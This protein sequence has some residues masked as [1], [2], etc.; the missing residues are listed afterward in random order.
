MNQHPDRQSFVTIGESVSDVAIPP[1]F[2]IYEN[3]QIVA[4][5][6]KNR[7]LTIA[8]KKFN[9]TEW[10]YWETDSSVGWDSHN[11]IDLG[12]DKSG[13]IHV[14]GNMHASPLQ[15]W[16]IDIHSKT[17]QPRKVEY[18]IN[19][20]NEKKITYPRF[21]RSK[22]G[23]LIFTYRNGISGDGDFIAVEWD[24][25]IG[26]YI[27]ISQKPIIYGE[28]KRN[29]YID[30]N[31]PILGP[32]GRWHLVWAWRN[33][34]SAETTHSVNYAHSDN[35]KLWKTAAGELLD[36]PIVENRESIADPVTTERGLINNNIRLGFLNDSSP[37]IFYH[38]LDDFG[39]QQLWRAAYLNKSWDIRCVSKWDIIWN[40]NGVG[41][42]DFKIEVGTPQSNGIGISIDVR[43]NE[44]IQ[45][46]Y[47]DE[48][49]RPVSSSTA[50]RWSNLMRTTRPDGLINRCLKAKYWIGNA[51]AEEWI[52]SYS[53]VPE[54]RDQRPTSAAHTSR[55]LV[56][57]KI[58]DENK[59]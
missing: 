23:E 42:L 21:M 28:G 43:T 47:F 6:N 29:A 11:Y 15:Y 48:Q 30:T 56:L 49:A 55:P 38:K 5:Y 3:L 52:L 12:I 45:E 10:K 31:A 27:V 2:L 9:E 37:V 24:E 36:S 40:F 14:A 20:E 16:L 26:K 54:Q 46:Y 1:A 41:S 19:K 32:D 35:L 44:E 34:P 18:L 22:T 57:F 58:P 25:L 51:S 33:T 39:V 17:S 13:L 50:S 7:L 59:K 53:T 4:F 8:I